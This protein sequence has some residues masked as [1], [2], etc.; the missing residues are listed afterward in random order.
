VKRRLPDARMLVVSVVP[1]ANLD[2]LKPEDHKGKG[3]Y[4][5]FTNK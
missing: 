3:D 4:V 1:V 5:V 2:D